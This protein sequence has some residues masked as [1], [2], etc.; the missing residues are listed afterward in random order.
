MNPIVTIPTVQKT[1][2]LTL[3]ADDA[4]LIAMTLC[5]ATDDAA[6][7]LGLRFADAMDEADKK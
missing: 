1:Y 7:K 5:G 6:R 4:E 2:T 3:S